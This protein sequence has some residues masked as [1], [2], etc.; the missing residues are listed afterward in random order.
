MIKDKTVLSVIPARG[1]SKGIKLKNLRSVHGVPLVNLAVKTSL[2][3]SEIDY[4][5]VSTDNDAIISSV[6][7]E[8]ISV[9]TK[10]PKNLSGDRIGDLEVL[11]HALK[12][13]ETLTDQKFDFI[14]MLQP[15][16]PL[17]TPEHIQKALEILSSNQLDAV[18]SVS[19]TDSKS[20][21]LKQLLV[22]EK[23]QLSYYDQRGRGIIARQQ[24]APVYHRNG[25]VYAITRECLVDQK[26]IM[27]ANTGSLITKG[28]HISIDTEWDLKLVEYLLTD[29]EMKR[30]ISGLSN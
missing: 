21:P 9:P 11:S 3:V 29:E 8:G 28:I 14:V 23:D 27:G 20:H 30:K 15:T 10:R 13:S 2:A 1:G 4:T 19:E 26:S 6:E 18:W 25:V 16:S 7:R 5:F 12:I 22:N 17:R 24:L